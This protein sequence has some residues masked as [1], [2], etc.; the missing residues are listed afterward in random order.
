L[1]K[2]TDDLKSKSESYLSKEEFYSEKDS[3]NK[4][5]KKSK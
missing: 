2:R 4:Q 1:I 3:I 5:F